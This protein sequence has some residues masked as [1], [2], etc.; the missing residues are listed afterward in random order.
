MWVQL[1][2][3]KPLGFDSPSNTSSWRLFFKSS[4]SYPCFWPQNSF[5]TYQQMNCSLRIL[6]TLHLVHV[7]RSSVALQ[8]CDVWELRSRLSD[9]AI[10]DNRTSITFYQRIKSTHPDGWV[11]HNNEMAVVKCKCYDKVPKHCNPLALHCQDLISNIPYCLFWVINNQSCR[12]FSGEICR[13][14]ETV[15]PTEGV[16]NK[17][18]GGVWYQTTR[19]RVDQAECGL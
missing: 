9:H 5:S 3:I 7:R 12:I 13:I 14:R 19:L 4:V 2:Q 6:K 11:Q 10:E 18:I 15:N 1:N 8:C 16:Y 17:K